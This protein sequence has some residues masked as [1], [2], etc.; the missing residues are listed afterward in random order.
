[1][2][3]C[4]LTNRSEASIDVVPGAFIAGFYRGKWRNNPKGDGT[5]ELIYHIEDSD[6]LVFRGNKL[7]T[8]GAAF[9]DHKQ[10]PDHCT[11][12]YHKMVRTILA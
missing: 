1:M 8:V 6:T 4:F 9:A 5:P 12:R 11:V 3:L 2:R 10:H 7:V